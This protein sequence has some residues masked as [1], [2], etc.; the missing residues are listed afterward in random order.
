VT[1]IIDV[2]NSGS[3]ANI[4]FQIEA[5]R[6]IFLQRNHVNAE[7]AL[8]QLV[9]ENPSEIV[10]L[11]AFNNLQTETQLSLSD[12][13]NLR[14]FNSLSSNLRKNQRQIRLQS[15]KA[16]SKRFVKLD[17]KASTEEKVIKSEVIELMLA[18]ELLEVSFLNE[19]GMILQIERV[20]S[21]LDSEAVP[22]L[23]LPLVYDFLIGAFWIKFTTLFPYLQGTIQLLMSNHPELVFDKHLTLLENVSYMTQLAHEN[24]ELMI[25]LGITQA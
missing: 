21:Q 2:D 25:I 19:K 12:Q 17:S 13:R 15:L 5:L 23:Y 24:E 3:S 16:L 11:R 10:T 4:S 14:L 18:F 20:K 6:Q 22:D 1:E 7:E 8:I 9:F